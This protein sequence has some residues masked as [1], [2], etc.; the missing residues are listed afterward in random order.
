MNLDRFDRASPAPRA[1][2]K[3]K[4]TPLGKACAQLTK[5]DI[6]L[7]VFHAFTIELRHDKLERQW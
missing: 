4:I 3:Y 7:A 6:V 1:P 2:I 5:F